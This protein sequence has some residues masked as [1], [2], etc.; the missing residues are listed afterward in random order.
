MDHDLLG[1]SIGVLAKGA[2]AACLILGAAASAAAQPASAPAGPPPSWDSLIPCAQKSDA[3]EGFRCYQAAMRAAG[4]APNPQVVAADRRRL[5]GLTLPKLGGPKHEAAPESA[6]ASQHPG[7]A[8]AASPPPEEEDQDRVTVT[9]DQVA[10]IPP[11]NRLLM[12]TTEGAV[13]LQTDNEIVA[14]LPKSGQ[15]MS[16]VRGSIGGFFCRFD[17]R[18]QVRCKRTH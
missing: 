1:R 7:A 14:P 8:A 16:V 10:L 11:A 3:V 9:L 6:L 12:V 13:W 2:L 17:K 15:S 18:T 4:Y 5:F